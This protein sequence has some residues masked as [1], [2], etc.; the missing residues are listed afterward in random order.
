MNNSILQLAI[1]LGTKI[2]KYAQQGL[3][4]DLDQMSDVLFEDCK[5]FALKAMR[6]LT[7]VLNATIRAD[8]AARKED[9]LV[10]KE[11]SRERTVLLKLGSFTYVR[12]YYQDKSSG[13]YRYILDEILQVEKYKRVS[14]SVSADLVTK[15]TSFS[16]AKSSDLVT[17]GAVSRQTV[18]RKIEEIASLEVV[19]P[20]EKRE[21]KELHIYADEDH[22]HLQKARKQK[23][24]QSQNLPL[25]TVTEG[26]MEE[27]KG[28][29]RNVN[30]IH[31]V[32]EE[33]DTNRLWMSAD[34]YI[35]KAYDL[36]SLKRIVIHGDGA[37]WIQKGLKEYPFVVY[38]LDEYHFARYT[39]QIARMFPGMNVRVRMYAAI[40]EGDRDR[41]DQILKNLL[42]EAKDLKTEKEV[43]KYGTYIMNH[44][45]AIRER[46]TG[47]YPGS[48]TEG[49]VSHVLSK[50]MSRDPLGWS[51]AI[52]G[53]L[54]KLRVYVLNGG[55]IC[56]ADFKVKDKERYS[57]Y[58]ERMIE[59]IQNQKYDWSMY[60]H[61]LTPF[62]GNSGTQRVIRG[63]GRMEL[64]S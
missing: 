48:C 57:A 59:E 29:N 3:I 56:A 41:A 38:A 62:D 33:M 43:R 23:G 5:T 2:E 37:P 15:A 7:D 22:V 16:Y 10:L 12:D 30:A 8:K 55:V 44:F 19:I 54:A 27:S 36:E 39:K 20:T 63:L 32:D 9:G 45:E 34:G 17:G 14:D 40:C 24:K 50:R 6:E 1:E 42:G 46:L 51:K 60:E 31:F 11:K 53:K 61:E 64:V 35:Q 21:I 49:L 25:I 58:S 52:A 47:G 26:R 4:S 28:R 13:E 18:K